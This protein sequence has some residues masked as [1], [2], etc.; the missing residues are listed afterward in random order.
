MAIPRDLIKYVLQLDD[1]SVVDA[2][3]DRVQRDAWGQFDSLA[4]SDRRIVQGALI[5]ACA[6]AV[7]AETGQ[8]RDEVFEDF[9]RAVAGEE[10]VHGEQME[11]FIR[12]H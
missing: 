3:L 9:R 2:F 6:A 5:F 4:E 7:D 11:N 1:G 10:A 12:K 8:E